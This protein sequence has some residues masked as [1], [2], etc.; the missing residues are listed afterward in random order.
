VNAHRVKQHCDQR[1]PALRLPG[2]HPGVIGPP[3]QAGNLEELM[4]YL[5]YLR[6]A[7][8][9]VT[10]GLARWR[11]YWLL[12]IGDIRQR[13]ARSRFGQFWITLS[14][15]I[16]VVAIGTVY[17][18]LFH[19]NLHDFLP[20]VACNYVTWA[21]IA[22]LITD[23]SSVFVQSETFL[24]HEPLPKTV[25]IM[26]MLVRNLMNFAHNILIVPLVFLALLHPVGWTLLLAPVGL[27][28]VMASGLCAGFL[29]GVLCT[30]F[31]DL[32]QIVQ[33][34]VQIVFF[35]TPVMWP[36]NTLHGRA[37]L[38]VH[39]NPFAALLQL[40]AQPMLGSVPSWKA[41]ALA[42]GTLAVMGT[43]AFGLFARFR[44]RIVYWL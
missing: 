33:N 20:Y 32:P 28:I 3:G 22:G 1:L 37:L 39:V 29:L 43:M 42:L 15:A 16:F 34:V 35:V 12:G 24:R 7:L 2:Y 38:L 31:R 40:V 9:D 26:R 6:P 8:S 41:Y 19:Q 21:L 30:R 14:M 17:G 4:S 25:F 13:Y 5:M 18:V 44:A 23:S 27:A 10:G 36:I 11:I